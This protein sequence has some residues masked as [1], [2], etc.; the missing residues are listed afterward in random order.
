[1]S[2]K[3]LDNEKDI[4]WFA[5]QTASNQEM[6]VKR[7][8][9][10]FIKIENLED[11]IKEV[12]VPTKNVVEVKGGRKSTKVRKFYPGYVFIRMRLFDENGQLLQN[13]AS[14]VRNVQGVLGFVGGEKP[15]PLKKDEIEGVLN[16]LE[17]VKGKKVLK[18][19]YEVGECV[20]IT[21]GPFLNLT[22]NIDEVDPERG[23]LK[24]SVS[25]FGRFTPVELEY[26]QVERVVEN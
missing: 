26:W 12:L 10:R 22:G 6:K 2:D 25:I 13:V 16:Q 23:K 1:M 4:K 14:F 18:V 21:D 24:I 15:A 3:I 7:Y 9:E 8:L 19:E 11:Y 17:E 5:V 20:K